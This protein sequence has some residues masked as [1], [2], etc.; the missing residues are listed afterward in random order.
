MKELLNKIG[1]KPGHAAFIAASATYIMY[2]IFTSLSGKTDSFCGQ[3]ISKYYDQANHN[4]PT[5]SYTYNN[6]NTTKSIDNA[7]LFDAINVADYI[8]KNSGTLDYILIKKNSPD[9][10][11]FKSY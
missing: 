9:T 5:I 11:V 3:I 1:L 7:H 2:L 6:K 4:T 8:I 10:L